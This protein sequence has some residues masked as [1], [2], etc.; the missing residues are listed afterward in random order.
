MTIE[1]TTFDLMRVT[2]ADDALLY[3]GLAGNKNRVIQYGTKFAMTTSGLNAYVDTGAAVVEG[4]LIRVTAQERIAI[5]A[6][7]SGYISITIDL[8]QV[9]SFV[10]TPGST[11][12]V[13]TNNQVRIETVS[14]LVQQDLHGNGKLYTFALAQYSSTASAVTLVNMLPTTFNVPTNNPSLTIPEVVQNGRTI[15][16]LFKARSM[17]SLSGDITA[18]AVLPP[19][20]RPPELFQATV[21]S[22]GGVHR[23]VSVSIDANGVM[24]WYGGGVNPSTNFASYITYLAKP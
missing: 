24:N 4:R 16:M 6:N 15:T 2:P 17:P 20:I 9:N 19:D 13:P 8:T 18:F 7:S 3:D 5:P 1:G 12:Y 22:V 23:V 10:G 21:G 14:S 11:N